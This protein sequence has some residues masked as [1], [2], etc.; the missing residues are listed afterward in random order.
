MVTAEQRGAEIGA[1]TMIRSFA[2]AL[3]HDTIK[4]SSCTTDNV[5]TISGGGF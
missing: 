5:R 4:Q 2:N 1:A 3:D